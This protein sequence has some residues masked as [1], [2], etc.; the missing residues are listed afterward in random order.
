M[1]ELIIP[2]AFLITILILFIL[3]T[4]L[5]I[6]LGSSALFCIYWFSGD[7]LAVIFIEVYR[8]VSN[9]VLVSLPLFTFAGYIMAESKMPVRMVELVDAMAG[10]IPGSITWV[11]IITCA[12]FT[13]F[14]GASGVTIV[15][16][17]GLLLPAMIK[18]AFREKLSLG[19]LT[20]CGSLGLLF[21]PSIPVILYGFISGVNIQSIFI[22]GIIPGI[23]LMLVLGGY[24]MIISYK[25]NKGA[26]EKFDWSRLLKAVRTAIWEIPLPIMILGGIYGGLTTVT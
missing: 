5:F 24:T 25:D 14:T 18:S 21:P 20:T 1:L 12:L 26:R 3:G 22:A 2:W 16:L 6:I 23:M 13:A 9:P 4:P 15:A 19:L 7:P 10:W 17:G 11:A 8:L